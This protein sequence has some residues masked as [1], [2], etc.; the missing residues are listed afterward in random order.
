MNSNK[1]KA[2]I[3]ELMN[4]M[5]VPYYYIKVSKGEKDVL[6]FGEN[7]G[8]I[9][10]GNEVLFMFSMTKP[11]TS[12]VAMQLLEKGKLSLEEKVN[13]YLPFVSDCFIEDEKGQKK[14]VGNQ[15][16][17]KHLLTMTAGF[18][19][20]INSK[21]LVELLKKDKDATTIKVLREICK[22]ALAF[23]VGERFNY[24]FCHDILVGVIEAITKTTFSDYVE[25]NIF[26][27]LG[28]LNSSFSPKNH[29]QIL[30]RCK[31]LDGIFLKQNKE[32]D[33]VPFTNWDS[34]GAGLMST[35]NDYYKFSKMLAN[36]GL[37]GEKRFIE[38]QTIELWRSEQVKGLDVKN[39]FTCAQGKDYS[40]GLGVRTRIRE[41][42]FNLPI[43]EFGWDGADGSYLMVD[44]KNN[45]SVVFAM[46]NRGW[47]SFFL[48]KHLEIV[49]LIYENLI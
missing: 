7:M 29:A 45:V 27:P 9:A 8:E 30:D 20:D 18:G 33:L 44:T 17:I 46:H 37:T 47:T 4:S 36:N 5:G 2:K 13:K 40:Y 23:D 48:G 42:E 25:E 43:G 32:N 38:K 21:Y 16:T 6:S 19:Y 15:I 34:G 31:Y 24:G 3:K 39:E 22:S 26:L 10:T 41:T 49:K 1:I 12:F 28:M 14:V 35:A 11:L